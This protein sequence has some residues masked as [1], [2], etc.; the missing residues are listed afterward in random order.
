MLDK[1]NADRRG[2]ESVDRSA[3]RDKDSTE[4][5][6]CVELVVRTTCDTLD[7]LRLPNEM[8]DGEQRTDR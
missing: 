1:L 3:R 8:G 6:K 2:R 7:P 5:A 4:M